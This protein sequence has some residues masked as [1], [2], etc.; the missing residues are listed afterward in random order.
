MFP[1]FL[2]DFRLDCAIPVP[3]SSRLFDLMVSDDALSA[4]CIQVDP[5]IN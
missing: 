5:V 3:L 2:L 1:G 4:D